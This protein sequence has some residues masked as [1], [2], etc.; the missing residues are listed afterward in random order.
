MIS[1]ELMDTS[2]DHFYKFVY[3]KLD[4]FI[5]ESVLAYITLITL[6]AMDYLRSRW[7]IIHQSVKP[8]NI[9]VSRTAIKLVN[10]GITNKIFDMN[11][12]IINGSDFRPELSNPTGATS[13]IE[14]DRSDVWSLG[15]TIYELSKGHYP[16]WEC[17]NLYHT[18]VQI[19]EGPPLKLTSVRL[20]DRC[21]SFVNA[22]L[23]KDQNQRQNYKELLEH[24]F[25]QKAKEFQQ[26]NYATAYL[27]DVINDLQHKTNT[28]G[29]HYYLHSIYR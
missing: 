16:L 17:K 28:S 4:L 29:C 12:A 1:M 14:D 26:I 24:P 6:E 9:L 5:P 10:S 20:S 21:K 25:L 8:S 27:S 22:Y 15:I 13:D 7:N 3:H 2:F 18:M 23:N 19:I 11:H